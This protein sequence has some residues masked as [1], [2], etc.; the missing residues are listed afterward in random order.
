M[1]DWQTDNKVWIRS[2][3]AGKTWEI[4]VR[5]P[6]NVVNEWAL[7]SSCDDVSCRI[8]R[9]GLH[10]DGSLLF[11]PELTFYQNG[12][13]NSDSGIYGCP[14][15]PVLSVDKTPGAFGLHLYQR[16]ENLPRFATKSIECISTPGLMFS[17]KTSIAT[18]MV[19]PLPDVSDNV[20]LC[21]LSALRTSASEFLSQDQTTKIGIPPDSPLF[22]TVTL[23]NKGD[24]YLH[25]LLESSSDQAETGSKQYRDLPLGS[26]AI[27]VPAALNTQST[28]GVDT[29]ERKPVGGMNLRV[30]LDNHYPVPGGAMLSSKQTK[31]SDASQSSAFFPDFPD[32]PNNTNAID[33]T[34]S[35]S[36]LKPQQ[37][38]CAKAAIGGYGE[39]QFDEPPVLSSA[40]VEKSR[41]AMTSFASRFHEGN[42]ETPE[43]KESDIENEERQQEEQARSDVTRDILAR[44]RRIWVQIGNERGKESEF[45]LI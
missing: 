27:A 34:Q 14:D 38:F 39:T 33:E 40:L 3:S 9:N 12:R 18:S 5:M 37:L 28:T 17:D 6:C 22:C 32:S 45:E 43:K 26:R 13:K 19:V 30:V 4:D 42:L 8:P 29:V 1:T 23:T 31:T 10:G 24:I 21:G 20:F 15:P 16:P 7:P 11:H 36:R 41:K 25:A 35:L 44:S 2:T